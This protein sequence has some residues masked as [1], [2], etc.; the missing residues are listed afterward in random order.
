MISVSPDFYYRIRLCF[1]ALAWI[2]EIV[3]T[4]W[5]DCGPSF[6]TVSSSARS[7]FVLNMAPNI[8]VHLQ[9]KL[10]RSISTSEQLIKGNKPTSTR[11][12]VDLWGIFWIFLKQVQLS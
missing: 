3:F 10:F 9:Q 7:R 12:N 8:F 5:V 1:A 4:D 6:S 11:W 2:L